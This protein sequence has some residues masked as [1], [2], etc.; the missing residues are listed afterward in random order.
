VRTV[1]AVL[2]FL[3]VAAPAWA[4]GDFV[5]LA[6]HGATVWVVGDFGLRELDGRTGETLYAPLPASARYDLGAAISGD[7]LFVAAI[8]NE[9]THGTVTRI[10]LRT[11]ATRVVWRSAKGTAQFIAA[12][13]GGVYV[14]VGA[15]SN[16]VLRLSSA[17][18]LTGRWPI[19]DAGRLAADGSGC[20]V[21]ASHR[22]LHIE[23]D[24]RLVD[25]LSTD[26]QEDVATAG[27]AVWLVGDGTLTRVDEHSGAI[28]RLRGRG[29][30]PIGENHELAV[31]AG[32]LWTVDG[33]TLE[34]RDLRTGAPDGRVGIGPPLAGSVAVADGAV[35]VASSGRVV[36]VDPR[37]LRITLRVA[38]G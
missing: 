38:L 8:A 6:P 35:W 31:G 2:A 29:M 10:D 21:A 37:T 34:R 32:Y 1:A 28:R 25:V 22:L 4:G 16:L 24:G 11:H 18:R 5:D 13:A 12:G 23:P 7:A 27:G 36:R 33:T 20:W 9:Y 17:G 26:G 15:K 30:R 14:L 3:A 19:G